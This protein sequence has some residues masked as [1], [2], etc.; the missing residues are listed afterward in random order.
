MNI[1]ARKSFPLASLALL[2]GLAAGPALAQTVLYYDFNETGTTAASQGS[3][4]TAVT[5]RNDAGTATDLHSSDARGVSE[6][7]GD[8]SYQN[9]GPNL[10]GSLASAATN[11]FRADQADNNAIDALT[12]FTISGWVKTEN[13]N[14][15]NA[16]TPR[17]V[18]NHDGSANGFNLQ[19]Y[20]GSQGDLKLEVDSTAAP[21][22][23]SGTTGLYSAKN[24]WIFFA[25]RYDGNSTSGNVDFYRG[26]RNDAEAVAAGAGSAA[27]QVVASAGLGCTTCTLNRGPVNQ[28][29]IGLV[30]GNRTGGDRPYDGFIDNI[31]ID[32]GLTPLATL[33]AYRNAA[34]APDP[35]AISYVGTTTV[36]TTVLDQNSNSVT[37]NE[38]SGLAYDPVTDRFFAIADAGGRVLQLDVDF[39]A[40]AVITAATSVSAVSLA[41]ASDFEGIALGASGAGSAYISD[42]LTASGV[43]EFSLSTGALI[44][45]LTIPSV[46]NPVV[47]NRGFESLSRN[48]ANTEMLTAVQQALAVDGTAGTS[49]TVPSVA[50]MLRFAVT[51]PNATAAEQYAYAI[52]PLHAT[53]VN[54]DGSSLHEVE[55]LPDG[56]LLSIERSDANNQELVRIFEVQRVG[57]TDVSQGA[58]ATGLIGQ[59]YT[60]VGKTLIFSS[61]A[62]GK[63]E[64]L[65]I[66]PQL[67]DGRYAALGVEDNASGPHVLHSFI[68]D[69]GALPP[70]PDG[71]GDGVPDNVDNC[72][73]T[74]NSNQA[75]GDGDGVGDVC[76]NCAAIANADQAD[77]DGDGRGNVC[78]NCVATP[79]A[80]QADADGDLVGD[81]CDNCVATPNADQADADGDLVGDVCDNCVAAANADQA[82]TDGDLR[83]NA[84]DNCRLTANNTGAGAQCDSDG[85]GFGNRCDGDLNNNGATNAQD[86]TLFR[87]QLGDLSNPPTYSP[88]DINCN[89]AAV[90]AQDTTLFRQLLGNPPGPGAGP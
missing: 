77:T 61:N 44:Q 15:L 73:S 45:T 42:E 87:Q 35:V 21:E 65:A 8:R 58:T 48:L 69:I 9:T 78:D 68:V 4:T 29:A 39:D 17:I 49:T 32:S 24:T 60:P 41:A 84:C 26:F 66:G 20:S 81:V 76:D 63:F 85:D 90:N 25:V 6:L 23:Y 55:F 28:E 37:V 75:D 89:G 56:R 67:P 86:T 53:P 47:S 12:S 83:G 40:N 79:N 62:L 22:V 64:G 13:W 80:D 43:R 1:V 27:V 19:F 18:F 50:R 36:P 71:D 70:D 46:F 34:V 72:P 14:T 82:D 2:A 54:S 74:P 59:T 5:L 10:H 38:L 51:G 11:G 52:E 7:P 57:A 3:S 33:E 31:R 16:A 88:A 30:I